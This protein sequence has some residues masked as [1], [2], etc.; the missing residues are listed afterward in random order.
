VTVQFFDESNEI[1]SQY[2]QDGQSPFSTPSVPYR[3]PSHDTR[4]GNSQ[5]GTPKPPL[6]TPSEGFSVLS[7]LNSESPVPPQ[8]T[9]PVQH[10]HPASPTPYQQPQHD[11][12]STFVYQQA[13]GEPVLWPL[14]HE[15]EAMLLQHYIENVALFVS[16]V[17][18]RKN[19]QLTIASLT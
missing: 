10:H 14:E 9:P 7:L 15:Q 6:I 17:N 3:S 5:N 13:P 2:V 4:S 18:G 19:Q 11:G 8:P 1:R 16:T 12:T